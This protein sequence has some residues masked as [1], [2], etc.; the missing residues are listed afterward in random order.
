MNKEWKE[1]NFLTRHNEGRY[2]E[3]GFFI[4]KQIYYILLFGALLVS[5]NLSRTKFIITTSVMLP[6]ISQGSHGKITK[7]IDSLDYGDIVTFNYSG[8]IDEFFE[9]QGPHICRVVGLPG[10]SIA[11]EKEICVINGKMNEH[12]LI[13]KAVLDEDLEGFL[14]EL[15]FEYE[16]ILPNGI[17]ILIYRDELTDDYLRK[18][19][20]YNRSTKA[21][22]YDVQ[23]NDM[24]AIK[25]PENH[26][27]LMG[28]FRSNANDSRIIGAIPREQI[29]GKVI[30]IKPPKKKR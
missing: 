18:W 11:V 10:D 14:K 1:R 16:E 23:Y 27:F 9:I 5:C 8:I 30:E 2:D 25:V 12:R 17:I 4:M 29:F 13:G 26:Y 15:S 24:K 28:D 19:G 22:D 7:Q 3:Q 21:S 20:P 6:T